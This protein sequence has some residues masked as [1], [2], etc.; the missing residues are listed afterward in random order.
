MPLLAR[1]IALGIGLDHV[2][3]RWFEQKKDGS[4]HAEVRDNKLARFVD[5]FVSFPF[6]T[7]IKIF[8][9]ASSLHV[10]ELLWTGL[11]ACLCLSV[12]G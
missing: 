7:N 5:I 2:K 8:F 12:C 3:E 11:L 9:S 10:T 4:E 1:T 6:D